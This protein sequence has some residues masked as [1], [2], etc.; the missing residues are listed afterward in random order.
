[1]VDKDFLKWGIETWGILILLSSVGG[2]VN[3]IHTSTKKGHFS[4]MNLIGELATSSSV[5]ISVFM[6]MLSQGYG[7]LLSVGV[8]S[9][10]GHLATRLIYM[11]EVL[12]TAYQER[13]VKDILQEKL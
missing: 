2:F 4:I 10:S 12:I 3:W 13:K 11:L 7:D 8:S 1:M 6:C 9:V 5:G